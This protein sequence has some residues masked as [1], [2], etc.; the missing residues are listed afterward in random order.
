MKKKYLCIGLIISAFCVSSCLENDEDVFTP[1]IPQQSHSI[2]G[3][4]SIPPK[5]SIPN[6][7]PETGGEQGQNPI[8]P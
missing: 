4:D 1:S 7:K 8:K 6:G 3:K 5:D 2:Y